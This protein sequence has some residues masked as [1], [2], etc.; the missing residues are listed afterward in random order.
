MENKTVGQRYVDTRSKEQDKINVFEA[1]S[2][3]GFDFMTK[4]VEMVEQD[5]HKA[6][7]D[8]FV[9]VC[10]LMNPVFKDIPEYKMISRHTCPTPFPDRSVFH[11]IKKEDRLEFLW[12]VP[13]H[14][15]CAYYMNNKMFL[16]PSEY[17]ALKNVED[18]LDGTLLQKAKKLNGEINDYELTFYRKDVH[19]EP[20]T[21]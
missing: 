3:V 19:G 8:F 18:Y 4:L 9:E 20:I 10:I 11:Y 21:S 17:E 2:V 12:H 13:A 7:T 15:E 16:H 5:K 14:E 6:P 1:V